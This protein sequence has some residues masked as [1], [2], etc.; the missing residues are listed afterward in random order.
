MKEQKE[1]LEMSKDEKNYLKE[2]IE[3]EVFKL[4]GI[5]SFVKDHS[6]QK[7]LNSAENIKKKLELK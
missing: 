4:K 3:E 1:I 6:I 7:S 2:V 5:Y